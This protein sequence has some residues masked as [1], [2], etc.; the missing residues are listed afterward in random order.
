MK[1]KYFFVL[2]ILLLVFVCGC[3]NVQN[4]SVDEAIDR[5]IGVE[6]KT[7]VALNGYKFYLPK[8]M[9]LLNDANGNNVFYSSYEKYYLYVDLLS[10]YNK[11]YIDYELDLEDNI[12]YRDLSS[13]DK[14]GYILVK[15]S[16]DKF[17][18][19]I[20]YN[21]AKIEVLTSD[22]KMAIIKSL[23][24][25][26]SISYNDKIIE[27]MV[28]GNALNYD[29]EEFLLKQ[30]EDKDMNQDSLQYDGDYVDTENE[31]PDEDIIA[32]QSE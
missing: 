23:L 17:L 22:Y 15:K 5:V 32:V 7:S 20:Y 3:S 13:D 6:H 30:P 12:Y 27:S 10:Y 4:L 28:G 25:L 2:I 26:N 31:L 29:E 21:Y 19:N 24:V 18:L 9:T 8:G 14:K 1:K 11:K 16:Y